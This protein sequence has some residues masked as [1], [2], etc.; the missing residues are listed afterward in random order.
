MKINLQE[1]VD[2]KSTYDYWNVGN[3]ILYEMCQKYPFHTDRAEIIAKVWL[4]GRS[5]AAQIERNKNNKNVSDDFYS[6]IVAPTFERGFDDLLTPIR[7]LSGKSLDR[8]DIPTILKA[9]HNAVQFIKK[10]T[11]DNKRS[12]VSKYFHFHFPNLFFI[13]DSRVANIINSVIGKLPQEYK[14]ILERCDQFDPI[15]GDFTL[16]CLYFMD[17]CNKENI[18]ITLREIDSFLIRKANAKIARGR[19][20]LV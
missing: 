3:S 16:R 10:I 19:T 6:D 4:I 20:A 5:Y 2:F 14:S 17:Y 11:N 7:A 18:P 8:E 15:Y 1:V 12:F 13:Y 9:H